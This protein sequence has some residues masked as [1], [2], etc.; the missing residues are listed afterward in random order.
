MAAAGSILVLIA[1]EMIGAT[2]GLGYLIS[3]S[4]QSFRIP[5]MYA[6]ILTISLLGLGINSAMVRL[7]GRLT[8]WR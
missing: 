3:S 7:E 8:A 2:S 1:A 4:Q 5:E 6:G